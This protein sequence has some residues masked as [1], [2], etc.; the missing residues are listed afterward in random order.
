MRV[1]K[2]TPEEQHADQD[3]GRGNRVADKMIAVNA[4]AATKPV[5]FL[6]DLK[7]IPALFHLTNLPRQ[8]F[9]LALSVGHSVP[10]TKPV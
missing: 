1:V 5:V 3:E 2:S 10:V 7:T 8:K 4:L 6:I 9:K